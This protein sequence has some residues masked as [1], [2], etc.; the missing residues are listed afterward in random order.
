MTEPDEARHLPT[1]SRSKERALDTL[2]QGGT[3]VAA[4]NA[5]GVTR[6]T[7]STWIHHD[8]AFQAH[9]NQRRL[10][11]AEQSSELVR[12]IDIAA[13]GLLRTE[14]AGGNVT[15]ALQWMKT[16]KLTSRAPARPLPEALEATSTAQQ[17]VMD[18]LGW[19][20]QIVTR[21]DRLS[22]YR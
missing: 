22:N 21:F 8:D 19:D 7:V 5:A 20:G 3:T 16:R 6:Q 18:V 4:A 14:I 13:L 9:F 15:A 1:L 10:T 2:V 12:Q 17:D 11:L